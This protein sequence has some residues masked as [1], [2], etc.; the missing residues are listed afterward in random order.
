MS[1][2]TLEWLNNNVLVGFT[3][4]RGHAWHYRQSDQGAEPNHYAG[5]VPVA[6]V[7]R[8]LF[9]WEA[10][11]CPIFIRVGCKA[12]DATNMTD[13]G[14][15]FRFQ[16]VEDRKA[17]VRSDTMS[18]LGV[19]S[20]GY[21]PH[22]YG[23]WL[24]SNVANLLSDELAIGS[25]GLLKNGGRAWVQVEMSDNIKTAEGVEFRPNLLACTSFDG[26]LATTYK[27]TVQVVVCDN[28]LECGLSEDGL[29]FR[30]KHTRNSTLRIADAQARET[31]EPLTYASLDYAMGLVVNDH[32]DVAYIVNNYGHRH[33]R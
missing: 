32:D 13:D 27:R 7:H 15:P 2:E 9:G 11:E 26:S 19:F 14:R 3:D 22:P 5:A 20:D 25:A 21:A 24:V 12:E 30:L 29:T 17:I 6:D 31:G 16:Q 23:T 18:V 33:Y 8:R 4:K 28:T 10:R 1:Q